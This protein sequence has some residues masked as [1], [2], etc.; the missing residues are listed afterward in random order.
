M[1]R[2]LKEP[3]GFKLL[4]CSGFDGKEQDVRNSFSAPRFLSEVSREGALQGFSVFFVKLGT[5]PHF[6]QRMAGDSS[7][8]PVALSTNTTGRYRVGASSEN[9]AASVPPQKRDPTPLYYRVT[10]WVEKQ[11]SDCIGSPIPRVLNRSP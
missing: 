6:M 10:L 11:P 8:S 7:A 4:R 3:E 2:Y 5:R 1:V 9:D